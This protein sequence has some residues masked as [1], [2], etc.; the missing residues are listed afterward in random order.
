MTTSDALPA[1]PRNEA[2]A[3]LM[4]KFRRP[5]A[6]GLQEYTVVSS[7]A[8]NSL[9]TASWHWY[10]ACGSGYCNAP[11]QEELDIKIQEHLESHGEVE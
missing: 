4:A 11:S 9:P 3:K 7:A 1:E 8:D 2:F 6:M 10:C 5:G